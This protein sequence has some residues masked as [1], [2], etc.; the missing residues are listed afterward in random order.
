MDNAA[1]ICPHT[2]LT[3]N[4]RVNIHHGTSHPYAHATSLCTLTMTIKETGLKFVKVCFHA[5]RRPGGR[6]SS[7]PRSGSQR[8]QTKP[9]PLPA[10]LNVRGVTVYDLN[11]TYDVVSLHWI[12]ST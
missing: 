11:T 2:I 1:R 8:D 10:T 4:P 3:V 9:V 7:A 5:L 12:P 6:N